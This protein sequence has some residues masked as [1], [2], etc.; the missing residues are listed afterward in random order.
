[1]SVKITNWSKGQS[2][3]AVHGVGTT[4]LSDSSYLGDGDSNFWGTCFEDG[5][6]VNVYT[7]YTPVGITV[8][9]T[10]EVVEMWAAY[11]ASNRAYAIAQAEIRAAEQAV[12]DAAWEAETPRKGKTLTVVRG[13][14][15]AKGTTGVCVWYGEGQWG[16]R[17]G[18]KIEGQDETVWTA[19]S[20]VEV[21]MASQ[22]GTAA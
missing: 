16:H 18:M 1:M 14:K 19:A 5:K 7:G 3:E 2:T 8:D 6:W 17:V 11:V 9:A 22:I 21:V 10:A 12:Q 4:V 15:I 20:N 13:R